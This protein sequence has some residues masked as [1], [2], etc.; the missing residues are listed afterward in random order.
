MLRSYQKTIFNLVILFAVTVLA[1]T[2]L[3]AVASEPMETWSYASQV[4]D[5][6]SVNNH[7]FETSEGI[8]L[9]DTQRLLPEAE[10]AL[11]HL[12]RTT[13]TP[14]T[15]IVITHAHTDHYG[16][17]PVWK[18]AF[19]DAR[20]I[21]DETTLRSIRSDGRGFIEMR[22]ERHGDRFTTQEALNAAL[23]E[24]EVIVDGEQIEIGDTT[25]TFS[26]LG[27]SESESAT[28]VYLP[29]EDTLFVGDLVN[30]LAPA[31]PMEDLEAWLSQLDL[32]ESQFPT[33]TIYQGHGPAPV[34][35]G[36]VDKQ[37][38]FLQ[39]LQIAVQV[40]TTDEAL[41]SAE[42]EEVVL[43]LESKYP[44][45]QGV[46]GNTRREVLSFVASRVAQQMGFTAE[47]GTF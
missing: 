6:D 29:S 35:K 13:D 37:R 10:R 32:I 30:E 15:A 9:I 43:E 34:S 5:V 39:E 46:G 22:G 11:A 28:L 38:L 8:V 7:W 24:A 44:F 14:V 1:I 25:L 23:A 26:V 19:P 42:I 18:A 20:I 4:N 2:G 12:Q 36:A 40:R 16:G 33:A 45:Y 17:L 27:A 31:V 47:A 41:D 3:N 21:T